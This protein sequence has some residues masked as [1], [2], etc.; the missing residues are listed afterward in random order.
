MAFEFRTC[1]RVAFA[2]AD[3]A[4]IVH[5]SNY[6]RY[7]EEAE[8]AFLRSVSLSVEIRGE[9]GAIGFPRLSS[10]CEFLRPA[11]FEDLLDIHLWVSRKGRTSVSYTVVFSKDGVEIARGWTTAVACRVRPDGTFEPVPLPEPLSS[12]IEEAPYPPLIP[13]ERGQ[14][15][16]PG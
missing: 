4:G 7:M 5:F 15:G 10:S 11:R 3:C 12:R 16:G 8:H 1:R 14:G 2:E 6:F 13:R 9:G